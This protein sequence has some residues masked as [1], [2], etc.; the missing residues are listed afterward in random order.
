MCTVTTSLHHKC[1]F[2]Q[3][4]GGQPTGPRGLL[5]AEFDELLRLLPEDKV[6][7]RARLCTERGEERSAGLA[8]L[9][10]SLALP[11]QIAA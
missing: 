2:R 5:A 10:A 8:L 6:R 1:L 7:V 4:V 3:L 11:S 9:L